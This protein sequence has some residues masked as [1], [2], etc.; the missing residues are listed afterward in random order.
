[1][2]CTLI[3]RFL[4]LTVKL[5]DFGRTILAR[6]AISNP[7]RLGYSLAQAAAVMT[8][9]VEALKWL[10]CEENPRRGARDCPPAAGLM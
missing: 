8:V 9:F 1:M 3:L 2:T 6:G 7:C 4:V 10:D 5:S